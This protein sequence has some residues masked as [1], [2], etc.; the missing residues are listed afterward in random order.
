[1]TDQCD[2]GRALSTRQLLVCPGLFRLTR[3]GTGR[4][5]KGRDTVNRSV[6][7]EPMDAVRLRLRRRRFLLAELVDSDNP[8]RSWTYEVTTRKGIRLQRESHEGDGSC[9]DQLSAGREAGCSHS[10][11]PSELVAGSR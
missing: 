4:T 11:A 2:S 6:R 1:M 9:Q 5:E 3:P 10:V 7:L 8:Y